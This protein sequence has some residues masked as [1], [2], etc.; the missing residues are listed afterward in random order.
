MAIDA[1]GSLKEPGFDI[2]KNLALNMTAKYEGKYFGSPAMKVGVVV[3]GNGKL[4][5]QPDGSMSISAALNIQPLTDNIADVT[6]KIKAL[7]WQK[8]FTNMAQA[9][10][11][12][13]VMLGQ[14]GRAEAQSAVMVISDG[15]YSFAFQ[16]AEKARELKDKNVQIYMAPIAENQDKYLEHLKDW[17]S[18]PWAT[19]YERIPGLKALKYNAAMFAEK[20]LVKFCPDA[21][22]PSL[23]VKTMQV[24][25]IL[26]IKEGG[27]PS[28]DCGEWHYEGYVESKEACKDKA[29][30]RKLLAFAYGSSEWTEGEC[31]SE[32]INVDEA[33]WKVWLN[34]PKAPACP[35][36]DWLDNE[37][38]DTWAVNPL[39][40]EVA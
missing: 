34:D 15:K 33:Q 40:T 31:Y 4:L 8:G 11:L 27:W 28:D 6:T 3:F 24:T 17:A 21:M 18:K 14:K 38:F 9:L 10:Q 22:S 39:V 13:D 29:V 36:G 19:N 35:N 7:T 5:P 12:A 20:L 1:S 23:E 2:V 26:L 30:K 16:T 25:Q 37:Y 32:A